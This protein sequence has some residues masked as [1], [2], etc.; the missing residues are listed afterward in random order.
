MT[1]GVMSYSKAPWY[2]TTAFTFMLLI[3][4]SLFIIGSMIFLGIAS[5]IR[6]VRRQA[7]DQPKLAMA[8]RW[9][10]AVFGLFTLGFAA[11]AVLTSEFD[12]VYGFPQ[13]TFGMQP[14]WAQML[15]VLPLLMAL[16]GAM[17]LLFAG[18]AW[19]NRYW[20][21]RSRIHYTLYSA[22]AWGLV[23]LFHY[24]NLI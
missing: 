19:R 17:L 6:R 13:S 14:A 20:R 8:A 1:D 23:W 15:N 22:A 12:P 2:G 24:W 3:F 7:Y 11:G 16:A 18:L 4:A 9:T 10:S 21:M 5:L